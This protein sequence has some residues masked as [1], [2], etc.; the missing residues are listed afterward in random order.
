MGQNNTERLSHTIE[1]LPNTFRDDQLRQIIDD[2]NEEETGKGV[3]EVTR[4]GAFVTNITVWKT[5]AKTQKRTETVFNR[6][7]PFINS[8]VKTI[9]SEDGTSSVATITATI[10]R[11]VNKRVTDVNVVTARI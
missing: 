6:T 5:V 4:T 8:I 3:S 10:T 2:L 7:G 11:D 1:S 9:Y